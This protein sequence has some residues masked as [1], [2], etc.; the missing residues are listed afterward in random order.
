MPSLSARLRYMESDA[1]RP[2]CKTVPNSIS[3]HF[4]HNEILCYKRLYD[5]TLL[6]CVLL[7]LPLQTP[8]YFRPCMK[9]VNSNCIT[10]TILLQSLSC[11]PS[12]YVSDFL[13][14]S[15]LESSSATFSTSYKI[16][17]TTAPSGPGSPHFRGLTTTF[18]HTTLSR[19]PLDERSAQRRDLYLTTHNI[20]KTDSHAPGDIRTRNPSKASGHR[21]TP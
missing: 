15:F 12:I 9:H 1:G 20:H 17:G 5:S 6:C 13:L 21:R 4:G 16:F 19:T 2:Y 14:N 8:E 11:Y 3:L 18:R 10:T 7:I